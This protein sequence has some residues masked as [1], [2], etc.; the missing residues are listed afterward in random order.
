VER[1]IKIGEELLAQSRERVSSWR[2]I[3][4]ESWE[5]LMGGSCVL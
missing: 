5:N 1:E 2:K 4:Q 3:E